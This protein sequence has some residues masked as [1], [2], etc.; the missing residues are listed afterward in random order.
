LTRRSLVLAAAACGLL[1]APIRPA[2]AEVLPDS[3]VTDGWRLANGLEVRVRHIPGATGVVI[4]TGYRAGLLDDVAGREGQSE[5]LTHLYYYSAAGETPDRTREEMDSL[6]PLGWKVSTTQRVTSL[7][8]V[9][10]LAQF[11]G[12]LRQVATRMRGVTVTQ[13]GLTAAVDTVRRDMG[14]RTFGVTAHGLYWRVHALAEGVADEALLARASA[15]GLTGLKLKDIA[16]LLQA[17]FAPAN[18]CL[19]LAG[20]FSNMNIRTLIER[21]F[22]SIPAGSARPDSPPVVLRGGERSS[23]WPGLGRP[24]GVLGIVAPALDD[25]LHPSFY[26]AGLMVGLQLRRVSGNPPPTQPGRFQ[27]SVFDEPEL[28]RLYPDVP[29]DATSP[30]TLGE[31]F[32][33][34]ADD[35]GREIVNRDAMDNVRRGWDWLLGGPM[36]DRVRQQAIGTPGMLAPM[37]AGMVTRALWRGDAFWELYRRRFETTAVAPSAFLAWM[38]DPAHQARLLLVPRK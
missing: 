24:V 2:A 31:V 23:I 38:Q 16:P 17:R 27:F 37:T 30:A 19:A 8:E 6:R 13:A 20:D 14:S 21:E 11:P 26:L 32:D 12:V 1:L 34:I 15:R 9:A 7:T 29:E 33:V 28:L 3:T 22:G 25:S 36:P 5:L 35:I 4:T 18:G 10:S